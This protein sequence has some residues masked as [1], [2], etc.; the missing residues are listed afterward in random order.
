MC[1]SVDFEPADRDF[2]PD[3]FKN[4]T[5]G[6]Q[7]LPDINMGLWNHKGWLFY[8]DLNGNLW[9][10]EGCISFSDQVDIDGEWKAAR[11]FSIIAFVLGFCAWLG[12]CIAV[13]SEFVGKG[14]KLIGV[15]YMFVTLFQGLTLL[16]IP[17]DFCQDNPV[18]NLGAVPRYE[19]ECVW[20]HGI[21]LNISAIVLY[22]CAGLIC[23]GLSSSSSDESDPEPAK[24]AAAE[25]AEEPSKGEDAVA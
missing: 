1:N 4:A 24:E 5:S 8:E 17:S 12:N 7:R 2:I 15:L 21:K 23:L 22:F 18:L 16:Q 19:E 9:V 6:I 13:G 11:A 10:S 25:A 3:R 14:I 20:N